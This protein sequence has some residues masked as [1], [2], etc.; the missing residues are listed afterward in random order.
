MRCIFLPLL[1]QGDGISSLDHL[2]TPLQSATSADISRNK[3]VL[4][5]GIE[6][7]ADLEAL[8][9]RRNYLGISQCR[10][11]AHLPHLKALDLSENSLESAG[12]PVGKACSGLQVLVASKN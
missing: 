1:S 8:S 6:Q 10:A 3:L 4:L 5:D 11:L 9:L 12:P 7:A 2:I